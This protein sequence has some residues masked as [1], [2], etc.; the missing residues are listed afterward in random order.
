MRPQGEG[1]RPMSRKERSRDVVSETA[2]VDESTVYR[3]KTML[4]FML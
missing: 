3:G 1:L 2:P 4:H